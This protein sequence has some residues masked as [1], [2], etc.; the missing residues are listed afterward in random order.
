MSRTKI[1]ATLG[2]ASSDRE[3]LAGLIRRGVRLFRLNFSHDDASG[4]APLVERLR[5]LEG[6]MDAP[7]TLM[8]DIS[9]PKLRT[10]DTGRDLIE[11]G[12]RDEVLLGLP[13]T[14]P[15]P[16][17][18]FLC[19]DQPEILAGLAV[20]DAVALSDGMVRFTVA[21]REGEGLVRLRAETEGIIPPRK[22]VALPGK[23]LPISAITDKDRRDLAEA[24]GMVD[25][26]ALSYVQGPED[27]AEAR[28]ILRREGSNAPVLAKL[29]RSEAVRRLEEVVEAADGIMVARG[30]LGLECRFSKLPAMQKRIIRACNHVCKPVIVATHM[31][32]SMVEGPMPSRA[33]VTD[34]AN[35]VLDGADCLMLSEETA[36][37]RSPVQAVEAMREIADE[38]EG[39][40]FESGTADGADYADDPLDS[41]LA[42]S[43]RRLAE[44]GDA[45]ALVAHTMSGATARLI[46]ATRPSRPIHALTPDDGVRRFLQFSW[47]VLPRLV[48]DDGASHLDRA[49][50]FIETEE[51]IPSGAR[52]VLT[53]GQP[54]PGMAS[55]PTNVVKIYQK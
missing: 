50:A 42:S 48:E 53:A 40:F 25:C 16:D 43:A 26:V 24:A 55:G 9:G 54:K 2:P 39:Y 30:D 45:H 38:A 15:G 4:F 14:D 33:E 49:E 12:L 36:I 1:M 22:G 18:P 27:V 28:N 11:V 44:T 51:S 47:G 31:L 10:R 3:T 17:V 20:G 32:L 8:Q 23:R 35:A 13:E 34:V 7:L 29:E 46:S 41:V 5:R 52:V 21:R 6:E 19:L 37:G